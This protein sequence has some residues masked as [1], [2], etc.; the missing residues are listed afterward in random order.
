[1]LNWRRLRFVLLFTVVWGLLIGL[2]W[3]SGPWSAI[4]RTVLVGFVAMLVFGLFE[5]WPKRFPKWLS[6]WVLQVVG[7]ALVIPPTTAIIFAMTTAPGAPPFFED[8]ERRAGFSMIAGM[9]VLFGPWIALGALVRQKEALAR[10]QALAFDLERSELARQALDARLSL[11][12]AQ[13]AP[14]F[15]FNTL[16]NVQ[17]L[18]DAGSPR[19]PEVLRSLTAYLRAAVPR[20]HEPATT[21]GQEMEL[22][23]AY[24]EL[25]HMRMPDRLQF[26]VHADEAALPLRCPPMTL[27]TLV[28]NAVRHGIDPSEQGGRIDIDIHRRGDRCVARVS[29]TGAGLRPAGEGLGTGLTALRERL[30]LTFGGDAELRV[31]AQQPRG[32]VAELDF[33]ARETVS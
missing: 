7:V 2:H 32:V 28:E 30:Q 13:V 23:R 19:A 15:L 26:A 17:A 14:H 11:L 6:R 1:M 31:G 9:G 18:V 27:L 12:Q 16:A 4:K 25:M 22:V 20:L 10:H 21:L 24:L 8:A 29:D 33:P 5:Q 3:T